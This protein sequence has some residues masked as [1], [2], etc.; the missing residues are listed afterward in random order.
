MTSYTQLHRPRFSL[1]LMVLLLLVAFILAGCKM[2][3]N[4]EFIQGQWY[5]NN[6]HL[7]NIPAESAQESFWLFDHNSFETYGCCF[8]NVNFSGNYRIL[9]SE[10]DN[11]QLEL[12][13]LSGM[14]AGIVFNKDETLWLKINIDRQ[15]DSIKLGSDWFAR[16]SAAE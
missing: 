5:D 13:N 8:V 10:G 7:A 12:Y 16:T 3:P 15:A 1:S 2:D 14:N 9:K 11:L 4:E 6:D